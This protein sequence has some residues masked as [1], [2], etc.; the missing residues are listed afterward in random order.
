MSAPSPVL[1]ENRSNVRCIHAALVGVCGF[2]HG[3]AFSVLSDPDREQLQQ[4]MA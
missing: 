3:L 1:Q 2:R 4:W